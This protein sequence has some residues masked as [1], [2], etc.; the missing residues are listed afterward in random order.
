M[1]S[2]IEDEDDNETLNEM[3]NNSI[4]KHQIKKMDNASNDSEI[5]V[6]QPNDYKRYKSVKAIEDYIKIGT[7]MSIVFI[8]DPK[9]EGLLM[10]C[11]F[12]EKKVY[13]TTIT[14]I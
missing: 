9:V 2:N 1:T 5:D 12:Q 13:F 14:T 7:P 3:T 11:V 10:G 4:F 8:Q 6:D